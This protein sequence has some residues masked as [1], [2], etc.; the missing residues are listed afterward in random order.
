M[1]AGNTVPVGTSLA[2][3]RGRASK[4]GT[5]TRNSRAS[6]P[7]RPEPQAQHRKEGEEQAG[8]SGGGGNPA[9]DQE[10]RRKAEKAHEYGRQT[11]K[12]NAAGLI[13]EQN[14]GYT[15]QQL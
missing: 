3:L 15:G 4:R 13:A 12:D 10:Q 9:A 1:G 11:A 7:G 5:D 14:A 2:P 6:T 8:A